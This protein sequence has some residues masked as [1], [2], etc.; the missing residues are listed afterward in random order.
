MSW[1]TR[2]VIFRVKPRVYEEGAVSFTLLYYDGVCGLE[3]G[4]RICQVG[5]RERE[6]DSAVAITFQEHP[7]SAL[8]VLR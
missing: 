2:A 3:R 8:G 1:T 5:N 6:E 4:T 7:A